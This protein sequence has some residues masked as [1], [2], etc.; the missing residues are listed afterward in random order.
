MNMAQKLV[1][2][3][4]GFG[5]CR[6][7]HQHEINQLLKDMYKDVTANVH[8]QLEDQ[9]GSIFEFLRQQE[10]QQKILEVRLVK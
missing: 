7:V 2:K 6:P 4:L 8:K 10:Q 3:M 5:C 9:R 1:W